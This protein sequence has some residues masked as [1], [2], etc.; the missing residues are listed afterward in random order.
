[1]KNKCSVVLITSDKCYSNLE[2][3]WGYRET[4]LLGGQ[5]PY[6][7]S[8]GASELVIGS[9]VN[10]FFPLNGSVRIGVGRAGNVIGGGDWSHDRIVPDCVRAW[11][12]GNRSAA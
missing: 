10:S 1:M 6:S 7:A 8:K 12:K 5:D 3:V 2:W 11:A 9:H 4:D